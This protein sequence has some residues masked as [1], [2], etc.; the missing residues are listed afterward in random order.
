MRT[1][2]A[3]IA[4]AV[5]LAM[6]ILVLL[7]FLTTDFLSRA[8]GPEVVI[9]TELTVLTLAAMG[10]IVTVTMAYASV[11]LLLTIRSKRASIGAV[12]L[13]GGLAF[14]TIPFG[15]AVGGVLVQRDP[16]DPLANALFLLGPAAVAPG[17]SLILPAIAL[18]FPYGALPGPRWRLPTALLVCL[19]A[20]AVIL[21]VL[22]PGEIAG[23]PSR[24]PFGID[25]MP[26]WLSDL[27]YLFAALGIALASIL[28][29][30]AIVVRYRRG[31]TIDR[32][33][34]RWFVAAVLLAA[35]PIAMSPQPVVGG[36]A[37][38]VL[39]AVGLLLVPVSVWIAVTRHRLYEIDRIISRT[40]GW[41]VVT[42]VLLAV[43]AGLVVTLQGLLAPVTNQ[44]TLAVAAS[45][46]VAAALFQPVRR[47]VQ[48]A[49]DRRFDRGRYDGELTAEAFAL[50]VRDQVEIDT[51]ARDLRA[52]VDGAMSPGGLALW[53]R[54][55]HP[56]PISPRP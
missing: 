54:N 28:G 15:Y 22:R 56:S 24:N 32:L 43:F 35:I 51:L 53:L 14:A 25:A 41:G 16:Y 4:W 33:Q 6:D 10:I 17:Y 37:W 3:V 9:T 42:G 39:A 47:R 19:L 27:N 40:I 2:A 50:L 11:G 45:T 20:S 13:A 18:V 7:V 26:G 1:V 5:T 34:L 30:S 52:A 44:N 12:L 31:T 21:A 8:G 38:I 29:V 55:V 36:P 46:L 23:L 48:R 49:V